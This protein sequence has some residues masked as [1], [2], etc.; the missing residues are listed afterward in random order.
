MGVDVMKYLETERLI[1]RDF[2]TDDF[3]DVHEYSSDY[4]NVKHMMFGPNTPEQTRIYLKKQCVEE[5]NAEPR[6]HYNFAIELKDSGKVIGGI[7]IHLNWRRDD[8]ILGSVINRKY[9]GKG[10]ATEAMRGV[11]EIAFTQLGLH[12]VHGVCD[13]R[14]AAVIHLLEKVGLRNEGRM[15]KRGKARPE[16]E[17]T[18]FD[19]FGFAILAE[20]WNG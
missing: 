14:N 1:L 6:M 20:E 2:S 16:E 18:Y 8:A 19:Q 9:N 4:E 5:M 7:S 13:V 12:R 17:E 15:V 10:Y 3:D 11:L